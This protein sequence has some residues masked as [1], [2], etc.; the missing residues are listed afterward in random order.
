M[1]VYSKIWRDAG[2]LTQGS[3]GDRK[4][5][6]SGGRDPAIGTSNGDH[7][8]RVKRQKESQHLRIE[9]WRRQLARGTDGRV[10]TPP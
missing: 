9:E 8:V 2:V 4:K 6:S 7:N 3:R 1:T 5:G 10:K